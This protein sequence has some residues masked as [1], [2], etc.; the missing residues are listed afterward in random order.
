MPQTVVDVKKDKPFDNEQFAYDIQK[1]L[2]KKFDELFN[3]D[4][5]E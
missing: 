1:E 2:E 3:S 5:E 4:D